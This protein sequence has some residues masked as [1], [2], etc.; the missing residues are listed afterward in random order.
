MNRL[1]ILIAVVLFS[2]SFTS[3]TPEDISDN[4][5]TTEYADG[6]TGGQTGTI[7]PPPPPAPANP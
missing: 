4:T 7:N 2:I 3:C 1:Y 6:E 5:K